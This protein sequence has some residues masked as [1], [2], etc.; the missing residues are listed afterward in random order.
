MNDDESPQSLPDATD[1]TITNPTP[2]KS[3]PAQRRDRMSAVAV[4][5]FMEQLNSVFTPQEFQTFAT[6]VRDYR[7][8]TIDYETFEARLI[9]LFGFDRR[10]HL[11][12]MEAFIPAKDRLLFTRFLKRQGLG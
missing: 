8:E 4:R 9:Q 10:H 6:L 1:N 11:Q 3:P 7:Q 2:N 5:S 12:G